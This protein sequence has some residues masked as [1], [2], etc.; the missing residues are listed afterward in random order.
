VISTLRYPVP[1]ISMEF[2]F[3][4]MYDALWACVSHLETIGNYSFNAAITEP[5]FKLEYDQW[6][7]SGEI[8]ASI[9]SAGWGYAELYARLGQDRTGLNRSGFSRSSG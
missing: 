2:N 7:S 8:T 9:R 3:P 1:L 6:L 5:P 4:Q